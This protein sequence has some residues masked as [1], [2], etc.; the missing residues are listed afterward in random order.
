MTMYALTPI[1][2]EADYEKAVAVAGRLMD[3]G[4][5]TTEQQSRLEALVYLVEQYERNFVNV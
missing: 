3:V 2:S 5:R 1:T 4:Y